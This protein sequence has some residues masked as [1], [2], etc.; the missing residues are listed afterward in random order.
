MEKWKLWYPKPQIRY[1]SHCENCGTGV[2]EHD[3]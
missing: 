2:I 3:D 1:E